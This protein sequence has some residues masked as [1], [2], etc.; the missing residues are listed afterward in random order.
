[1]G[2]IGN[3]SLIHYFRTRQ[4]NNSQCI[5]AASPVEVAQSSDH[6]LVCEF[7]RNGYVGE[8]VDNSF[9]HREEICV[10]VITLRQNRTATTL[11][12]RVQGTV[13]TRPLNTHE[14]RKIIEQL[15]DH[16]ILVC[17][18]SS[19]CTFENETG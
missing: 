12:N 15:K 16:V 2:K 5:N 6:S 1:M 17:A 3:I 11:E 8:P 7:I 9:P 19:S 14:I 4:R 13:S 18:S 10:V